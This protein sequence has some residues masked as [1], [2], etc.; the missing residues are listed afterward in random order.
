MRRSGADTKGKQL[1]W[2]RQ[3][4]KVRVRIRVS[5]VRVRVRVRVS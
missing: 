5:R 1:K 2:L 4:E 3:V